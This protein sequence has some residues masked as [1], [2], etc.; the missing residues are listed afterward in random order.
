MG[1]KEELATRRTADRLLRE[2]LVQRVELGLSNVNN[3]IGLAMRREE[4]VDLREALQ[5]HRVRREELVATFV[6]EEAQSQV[7]VLEL[8]LRHVHHSP[9]I[10]VQIL[11]RGLK[12]NNRGRGTD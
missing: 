4:V 10:R 7:V 8:E 6:H 5:P 2:L 11:G 12:G 3:S 9:G 1:A